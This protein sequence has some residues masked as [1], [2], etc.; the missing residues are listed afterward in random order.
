MYSGQYLKLMYSPDIHEAVVA[1]GKPGPLVRTY[2]IASFPGFTLP[3]RNKAWERG[4]I[5]EPVAWASLWLAACGNDY[6]LTTLIGSH[7]ISIQG[8]SMLP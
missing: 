8:I 5:P 1:E 6:L 3:E 2:Q 4:Y 7:S